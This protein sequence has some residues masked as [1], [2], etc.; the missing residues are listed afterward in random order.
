MNLILPGGI[1][2]I[3]IYYG[4]DSGFAERDTVLDYLRIIDVRSFAVQKIE[5]ANA[6]NCPPI[7]VCVEKLR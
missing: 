4:G 5:M 7:F 1:I 3:G 2:T 6:D